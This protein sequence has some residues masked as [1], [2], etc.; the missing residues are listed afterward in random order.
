[1]THAAVEMTVR[2]S[3]ENQT[4]VFH[5]SHLPWKSLSRFPHSHGF[6]DCSYIKVRP[7]NPRFKESMT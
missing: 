5:S 7:E 6:Y 1:M 4:Q 2:V 3:L